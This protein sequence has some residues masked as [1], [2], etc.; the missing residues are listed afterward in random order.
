MVSEASVGTMQPARQCISHDSIVDLRVNRSLIHA[1]ARA[2]GAASLNGFTEA[3]NHVSLSR[4]RLVLQGYQKSASMRW[5]HCRSTLPD[6]VF[7]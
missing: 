2:A 7:T 4:T 1:D 3:L 5:R 6:Q